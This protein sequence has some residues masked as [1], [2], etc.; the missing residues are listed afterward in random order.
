MYLKFG[1]R[2][3]T[4]FSMLTVPLRPYTSIMACRAD[5]ETV[6]CRPHRRI[7]SHQF[8]G[9]D[10][11]TRVPRLWK[12]CLRVASCAD[13]QRHF[14]PAREGKENWILHQYVGGLHLTRQSTDHRS[15]SVHRVHRAPLRQLHA[16]RGIFLATVLLRTCRVCRRPAYSV[17]HLCGR[18]SLQTRDQR[19]LA[20]AIH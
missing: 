17:I 20:V 6:R 3:V 19:R 4:L 16:F 10:G 1:R 12:R 11:C 14:L 9:T 5:R 8:L 13:R 18:I 2:P 7:Q 15:L